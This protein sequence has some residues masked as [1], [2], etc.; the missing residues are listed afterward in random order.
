MIEQ[1]YQSILPTLEQFHQLAYWLAFFAALLETALAVGLLIPGSSFLL[2]LGALSASGALSFPTLV[3]FAVCGA[4]LGDNLNYWLGRRYGHR[5]TRDGMW[6]FKPSHFDQ[7]RHFFDRHGAKSVFL[8]RFIPSIKEIAPFVAGTVGMKRG[9]FFFWNV[10]GGIGWGLEWIGA[11][12]LFAQSLKLA[13]VWISRI[14]LTILAIV[15]I[16][17]FG[18]LLK[19]ALLKHGPEMWL[20]IRSLSRSVA[21]ALRENPFIVRFRRRHP[22][23]RK[24]V[25]QR[26]DPTHFFGL[27]LTLLVLSFSYVLALFGGVVEDFISADPF[28]AI[29]HATAQLVANYRM[30]ELVSPFIWIT[31]LGTRAI[32]VPLILLSAL[33]LWVL[34][35]P[36]FILPLFISSAGASI[37][38]ALGKIAFQRPR[39]LEAVLLE[40]SYSFPSGHATIAV[41]FY[42]FLGYLLIRST[43]S[44]RQQVNRF[45]LSAS[46]VF[47]IA[48]SR[49]V[50]G[51]H[52][53]SD[54]WAGLLVG[55]MW[56]IIAISVSEWLAYSGRI[57]F[58]ADIPAPSRSKAW[59]LTAV[60]MAGFVV[61]ISYWQPTR[62][63]VPDNKAIQITQPIEQFLIDQG[64]AYTETANGKKSQALG[65]II[66]DQNHVTLQNHLKASGWNQADK[67]S[68]KNMLRL[69]RHGDN[70]LNAPMAPAFWNEKINDFAGQ[71]SSEI[72]GN[73]FNNTLR[74]WKTPYRIGD[75]HV[76]VGIVRAIED[77]QWRLVHR[78]SRDIDAATDSFV[79]SLQDSGQL[80]Q[81]C[82]RSLVG[83]TIGN[84]TLGG[85]FFS[86][87]KL[88]LLNMNNS[89]S[90]IPNCN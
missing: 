25:A 64:I 77:I 68:L 50:L 1:L 33:I 48:L 39:P 62:F 7:A 53:L 4:I 70:Y 23:L 12:Y 31:A 58:K 89:G 86:R 15:L 65:F 9:V 74:I 17:L 5:W 76:F 44:W 13:E 88:Q 3:V 47:L 35:R 41:A 73:T 72:S 8:G 11:G 42:G 79:S 80:S 56:L 84:L 38:S 21:R 30:P 24:F 66:L 69:V 28:V 87:G 19:R 43:S 55:T 90:A 63:I 36:W 46:L 45:F 67:V 49:I 52:Y 27:P 60:G 18:W 2:L 85:D 82:S 81:H 78:V 10:L 26:T 16:S 6:F 20:V 75:A 57:D 29:D 59:I 32:V 83:P 54:V 71:R 34:K 40:Q 14:G 22:R 37:M 51:V 61:F